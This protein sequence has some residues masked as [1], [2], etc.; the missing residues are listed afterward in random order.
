MDISI[1]SGNTEIDFDGTYKIHK[2]LD[3]DGHTISKMT[4]NKSNSLEELPDSKYV[5]HIKNYFPGT[6]IYAQLLINEKDIE[7]ENEKR[8]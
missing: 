7:I 5:Y 2:S 8:I 3:N 1:I 6:I 4:F